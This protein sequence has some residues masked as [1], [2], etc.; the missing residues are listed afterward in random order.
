MAHKILELLPAD[1]LT[2][3]TEDYC[4]PFALGYLRQKF[5]VY[6]PED[7]KSWRAVE[8]YLSETEVPKDAPILGSRSTHRNAAPPVPTPRLAAAPPPEPT[9]H[10]RVSFLDRVKVK[11]YGQRTDRFTGTAEVPQSI[12]TRGNAATTIWLKEHRFCPGVVV[13]VDEV[14]ELSADYDS[15]VTL[16]TLSTEVQSFEG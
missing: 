7:K 13:V 8:K 12:V 9:V 6:I 10:V 15:G 2:A 14:G 3:L 4:N 11:L 5:H 16:D 1:I